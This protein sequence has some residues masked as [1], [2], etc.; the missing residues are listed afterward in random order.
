MNHGAPISPM[1]SLYSIH[2]GTYEEMT[3][4]EHTKFI[5][6]TSNVIGL[7]DIC[8]TKLMTRSEWFNV[9]MYTRIVNCP[10]KDNMAPST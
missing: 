4:K 2:V 1:Q 5:V 3:R 8:V 10:T 6:N 7:L 9:Y